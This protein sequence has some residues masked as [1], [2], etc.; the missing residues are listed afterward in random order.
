ML[1][2]TAL[3]CA[4]ALLVV[5]GGTAAGADGRAPDGCGDAPYEHA[6]VPGWDL[7]DVVV[8]DVLD[9]DGGL[10]AVDIVFALCDDAAT[11]PAQSSYTIDWHVAGSDCSFGV[12]VADEPDGDVGALLQQIC[13]VEGHA[14]WLVGQLTVSQRVAATVDGSEVAVRL[15]EDDLALLEP[16]QWAGTTWTDLLAT[17]G[18]GTFVQDG[19]SLEEAGLLTSY[20]YLP[21]DTAEPDDVTLGA[22]ASA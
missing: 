14:G 22:T 8:R 17:A 5:F 15:S 19:D 11:R 6:T 13:P 4:L 18:P 2:R 10:E 16:A 9:E 12:H 1:S 21:V 7:D 3:T 20:P